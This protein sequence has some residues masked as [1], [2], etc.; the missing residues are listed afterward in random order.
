MAAQEIS[1]TIVEHTASTTYVAIPQP[2][3][4]YAK[5]LLLDNAAA[6]VA[7]TGA[8]GCR[9]VRRLVE[10]WGGA[11]EASV[12]GRAGLRV[13]AHHAAL[14]NATMGRALELDDTHERGFTH[15]TI[16][17]FPVALAAAEKVGGV[18]GAD[19]LAAC[20]VGIDLCV[21]L[22]LA[23]TLVTAG[24]GF[25]QRGMSFT[26]QAG[27]LAGALTAARILG[28]SVE[29]MADSFGLAYSQ[30]AGN[31][32]GIVEGALAVRAQQGLSAAAALLA[33]ELAECG[34]TGPRQ[35]LEGRFGYYNTFHDGRWDPDVLTD[36]LGVRFEVDEVSIKP[37][38]TCK[39]THTAIAAA[40]AARRQATFDVADI[41][42]VDV[43][44]DNLEYAAI[45]CEPYEEKI[46]PDLL[47]GP[48]GDVVAQFSLPF[49]VAA[50][51]K[52]GRV[53]LEEVSAQARADAETLALTRRV[54]PHT[55]ESGRDQ[56]RATPT[57]SQVDVVLRS[58]QVLS[59]HADRAP[60]HHLSPLSFDDVAGKLRMSAAWPERPMP[61]G[62]VDELID[63]FRSLEKVDD[64]TDLC[65]LLTW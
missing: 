19:L 61:A 1:R 13:P 7:G 57:P 64:V 12:V 14:V 27:I 49:V 25:R 6:M 45:V 40:L 29:R 26:Y 3:L 47:C 28:L 16:G 63:T 39:N 62:Q 46:D 31:Q 8:R 50:A 11:P 30:C 42:R 48:H 65:R 17:V 53:T 52:H 10:G 20:A 5:T 9:E 36:G 22:S 41:E 44:V 55:E 33:A 51:L 21:R 23:P 38:P 37:Y 15:P 32:Q 43:H 56:E 54:R 24:A 59:G 18:N 60:G 4:D 35:P 34:I 2:T 58:G